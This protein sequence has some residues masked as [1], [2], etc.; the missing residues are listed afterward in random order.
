[1]ESKP[2]LPAMRCPHLG[3]KTDPETWCTY[4]STRNYCH[5]ATPA[6]SIPSDYQQLKCLSQSFLECP[7]YQSETTWRGP[8]PAALFVP[9]Y[10]DEQ[11]SADPANE[12]VNSVQ[13][14]GAAEL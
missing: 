14:D 11:Q 13:D 10:E 2:L 12:S 5:R 9:S 3:L 6:Q 4:A 7:V 1:L 8:I